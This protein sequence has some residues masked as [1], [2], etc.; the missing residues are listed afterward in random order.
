MGKV[1]KAMHPLATGQRINRAADGPAALISSENLRAVLAALE[2]EAYALQRAD[3]VASTADGALA[4]ASALLTDNA[5]LE[6][7]LANT[8]GLAPGEADVLRAQ[9]Q[10]NQQAIARITHAAAFNGVPL[11]DG[12]FKLRVAA[13]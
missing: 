2:A 11:F 3:A 9:T 1:Q 4:Q 8:A 10:S 5:G 12:S 13:S 6:V 7:Q